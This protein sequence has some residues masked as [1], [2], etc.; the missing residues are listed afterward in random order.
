MNR[1]GIVLATIGGLIVLL[2]GSMLYAAQTLGRL[3]YAYHIF[4]VVGVAVITFFGFLVLFVGEQTPARRI[5]DRD[6]RVAITASVF[7]S[8]L[9][10]VGIA[11]FFRE[12]Y[13]LPPFATTLLGS[14]T[15]I[16]GIVLA[17]YFGTSA[18]LESRRRPA[19]S[20]S[21]GATE[22]KP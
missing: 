10:L 12:E 7:L 18:F 9:D 6:L 2:V 13:P 16:V 3:G 11:S 14:F 21:T 4:S 5:T 22:S 8:Y 19:P 17:F 20:D 1:T 15:S